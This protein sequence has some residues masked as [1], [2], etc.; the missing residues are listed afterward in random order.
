MND[1]IKSVIAWAN[2]KGILDLGTPASQMEKTYEEC[3]ELRE[4]IYHQVLRLSHYVS[5]DGKRKNTSDEIMDAIGDITVTLIIQAE[6]QG[7]DFQDCLQQ[8]Y[9]V[10]SKRTGKMV[11]GQFVKD[12]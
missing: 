12:K 11:D 1:L 7:L 8:A 10:I 9:N 2:E 5:S 4:A 6:M 3:D